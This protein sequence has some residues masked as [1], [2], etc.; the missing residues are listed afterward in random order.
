MIE[1]G[2]SLNLDVFSWMRAI[3]TASR[4]QPLRSGDD[5]INGRYTYKV[6]LNWGM[7]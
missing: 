4:Y 1:A 2:V 5:S 6:G 7:S 3:A